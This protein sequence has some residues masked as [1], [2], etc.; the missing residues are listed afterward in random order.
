MNTIAEF[1]ERDLRAIFNRALKTVAICTLIGLPFI[2]HAWGWRSLLLYLLGAAI[3]AS[4]VFEWRRLSAAIFARMAASDPIALNDPSDKNELSGEH[5]AAQPP[6][7][8]GRVLVWFFVRLLAAAVLLYVSLRS[9]GGSPFALILGLGLAML[10]LLI[11]A[12][13]LFHA[14]SV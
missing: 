13:R 4:G 3:A 10:A 11:E 9:L 8:I 7:A 2:A 6:R 12:L 14:W 1:S 5:K